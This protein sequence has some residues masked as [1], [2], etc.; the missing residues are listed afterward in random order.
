M[1]VGFLGDIFQNASIWLTPSPSGTKP[2]SLEGHAN[3]GPHANLVE[4]VRHWA[5]WQEVPDPNDFGKN[6][7]GAQFLTNGGNFMQHIKRLNNLHPGEAVE[8]NDTGEWVSMHGKPPLDQQWWQAQYAETKE[9]AALLREVGAMGT[10][11]YQARQRGGT[12]WGGSAHG[13]PDETKEKLKDITS[14]THAIFQQ[15]SWEGSG[16]YVARR[17]NVLTLN[18]VFMLDPENTTMQE[19]YVWYCQQ[20]KF[21][22]TGH[23]QTRQAKL[24]VQKTTSSRWGE[25][26]T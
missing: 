10:K 6:I 1:N 17:A 7:H 3:G 21:A 26:L 14:L 18:Q 23:T 5:F 11:S 12:S 4:A 2:V 22:R 24:G 15:G 16:G 25:W 9:D 19:A 20:K 8:I 13:M